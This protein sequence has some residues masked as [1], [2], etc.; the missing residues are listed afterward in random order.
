MSANP[1]DLFVNAGRITLAT[2]DPDNL[3]SLTDEQF[4]AAMSELIEIQAQDR[5][6]NQLRFYQPASDECRRVHACNETWVLVCGGNGACLP[7]H[8]PVMMADGIYRP[9]GEIQIGDRVM[10]ADPVTGKAT[11]AAVTNTF[12]SGRK[13]VYRVTFSDG[14][15]FEATVEHQ[16]PLYLGSGRKT[17]KGNAKLPLKR[18]LGD[19][20]EPITRRGATNASKRISAVSP[21]DIRAEGPGDLR[22]DPWL[23]G[24]LL[25]DGG[26]SQKGVKFYNCDREVLSRA[27]RAMEVAGGEMRKWSGP[28]EYGMIG[29][30]VLQELRR[31]GLMGCN[32]YS[33]FIPDCVFQ[34]PRDARAQVLAGLIDT[35]GTV[36]YFVSVSDRLAQGV[37]RL[38]KSLG[39]KATAT[40]RLAKCQNGGESECTAVYLRLNERLP[41]AMPQKQAINQ[42]GR[43]IDYRRRVCR[44]A[45]LIGVFECGDI[46]VDH[47]AHCY[48]T[49][50]DVI[51]SNSKTDTVLA[52]M[53]ALCTGIIPDSIPEIRSQFRGPINCRFICESLTTV[54]HN[55]ILPKL[56]WQKWSG[57]SEPGGDKG[58]WGWIPKM[59][60]PDGSWESAWTEKTRTLR[61]ICRDPENELR[62]LGESTIQFMSHEQ[63][64]SDFAS[65]DFHLV[66]CDEPTK[67]AIWSENQA[68]TMRV[69]GR[70]FMVMTW[71]DDPSIPVDWIFDE[72]Y[73][74]GL[75]G[76]RKSPDHVVIE[77]STRKNRNLDQ[78]SVSR[79][80]GNWSDALRS[81][82][83]EGKTIR[84][85]NRIHPLFTD[86]P[87]WWSF[88]AGKV[89]EPV[90]DADNVPV[91]SETGSYDIVE[92]CHVQ[93]MEPSVSYPTVFILDPHPR[94]PHM[95]CWVQV[96]PADDYALI[97]SH[98]MEGTPVE[99]AEYVDQYERDNQLQVMLRYMDPNMAEQ[100]AAAS[101]A[102]DTSWVEEFSDA[103]LRCDLASDSSVGRQRIN[104]YLQPD[105]FTQRPRLVIADHCVLPIFQMKRYVWDDHK[106][107]LE[108]DMKQTAK[109]KNDDFPTMLKYLLNAQPLFRQLLDRPQ[110]IYREGGSK[111]Y[112]RRR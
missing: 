92:F 101:R 97:G 33:K 59:S 25:G 29:G 107:S 35:D 10:A 62:V 89:V 112:G 76:P 96:N 56:Q 4:K 50:D 11:P 102:R 85:S 70:M 79:Q 47:P 23:L 2:L 71:P 87:Q 106:K 45:E 93:K 28:V 94:K 3:D 6:Q 53:A 8:A 7:L 95:F 14:G 40:H 105:R 91:C 34:L 100:P 51:V 78:A 12:R 13:P 17:S 98:E 66:V 72:I 18:R 43:E 1:E 84:F 81:V 39:G 74:K 61:I 67:Y 48:I 110:R 90:Y 69:N 68:R 60:L 37:I 46:E 54:L 49:G 111:L 64:S 86:T 20:L 108:K 82:R 57:I 88:K 22:M 30:G 99:V 104:E 21:M 32:S 5:K 15:H 44:S 31:L 75:A 24:A 77:L 103:G 73:E 26:I 16:V 83:I 55:I 27:A 36:D 41:L 58:H 9:L 38:V 65:G 109:S 80:A 63:D 42:R 52:H 19:Y